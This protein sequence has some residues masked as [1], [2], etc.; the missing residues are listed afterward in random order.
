LES[1]FDCMINKLKKGTSKIKHRFS[2]KTG[3]PP[4]SLVYV[5]Q[6]RN[7]PIEVKLITYQKDHFEEKSVTSIKELSNYKTKLDNQWISV[8]GVHSSDKIA[9]IC[10]VFDIHPLIQ[11][12]ILNTQQRTKIEEFD[13]YF[14]I[15]FKYLYLGKETNQLE[16]EQISLIIGKNYLISFQERDID[17][18]KDIKDRLLESIGSIRQRK[19]DYLLYK[20]LDTVVD[21]Y[22]I[23]IDHFSDI[24]EEIEIEITHKPTQ[25]TSLKIQELKKSLMLVG[26]NIQPMRDMLNKIISGNNDLF[27]TK[28]VNYFK[29]IYDH[30][31]LVSENIENQKSLLSDL[32][33][34]YLSSMSNRLNQVMKV[35]TIISTIFMP[36]SFLTGVFGMNFGYFPGLNNPNAYYYF[37]GLTV[38]VV[39]V[40]LYYFKRKNWF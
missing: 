32:M 37:W 19:T 25:K 36:L 31:Y 33:N 3:L 30:A 10:A 16:S 29:D 28:N 40:M 5:G 20:I 27:E 34:I 39:L 35:L 2:S 11:E 14:F 21:H 12:D 1:S 13:E 23:L 4:E 6:D 24:S 26:K 8:N 38:T 22:F 7:H 15:T 9:E 17:F 18:F